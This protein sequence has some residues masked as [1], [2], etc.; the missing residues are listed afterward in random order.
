MSW[1]EDDEVVAT[2]PQVQTLS[3][4][5]SAQSDA[6]WGQDDEVV[7]TANPDL[8]NEHHAKRLMDVR[9]QQAVE[10]VSSMPAIIREPFMAAAGVGANLMSTVTRPFS[11][12]M[13][14]YFAETAQQIA[15]RQEA[16][17]RDDWSPWASRIY[18]GA[19]E[20][21]TQSTIAAPAGPYGIIGSF[22][23]TEGN[24]ALYDAE[25]AGLTGNDRLKYATVQG[26]IEGTVA[27]VFQR[28]APG[29]ERLVPQI[30]SQTMKTSGKQLLRSTAEEIP[31]ELLTELGHAIAES[32]YGIDPNAM[33]EEQIRKRMVDTLGQT[34]LTVG[35]AHATAKVTQNQDLLDALE[36]TRQKGFVTQEEAEQLGMT[37]EES[38][39]RSTRKKAVEDRIDQL[40][41][42]TEELIQNTEKEIQ[43]AGPIPGAETEV[44]EGEGGQDVRRGRKDEVRPE[45]AGEVAPTPEVPV[46][47][48][49]RKGLKE[50]EAA[51]AKEPWQMTREEIATRSMG[52]VP[53]DRV[54]GQVPKKLIAR[55]KTTP[56]QVEEVQQLY[57]EG[58]VGRPLLGVDYGGGEVRLVTGSN[59]AAAA[60]AAGLESIPVVLVDANA[61]SDHLETTGH[62]LNGFWSSDEQA[63]S[64][65]LRGFDDV[66]ANIAEAEGDAGF[67]REQVK[68][69]IREGMTVP[70]EVLADYP[71]L[72][73][74]KSKGLLP[75]P[76]QE[77]P[78]PPTE[79][80]PKPKSR[81]LKPPP[82]APTA[83][84]TLPAEPTPSVPS[85][86]PEAPQAAEAAAEPA[87]E[88]EVRADEG[89]FREA[90]K[91]AKSLNG[92]EQSLTMRLKGRKKGTQKATV[93]GKWAIVGA[94]GQFLVTHVP[95]GISLT[96]TTSNADAKLLIQMIQDSGVALPD[97]NTA[98]ATD[99]LRQ[100]GQVVK[101]WN[102]RDTEVGKKPAGKK[103]PAK[104]PET[105]MH[106]VKAL[107][108]LSADKLT[109]G[110]R[111]NIHEDLAQ[112]G[113]LGAMQGRSGQKGI[114]DLE[115]MARELESGG[116]WRAP[117]GASKG[118]ALLQA[119]KQ[120]AKTFAGME[121]EVAQEYADHQAQLEQERRNAQEQGEEAEHDLREGVRV[122]AQDGL[123]EAEATESET[124]E[125]L[126][127][128]DLSFN[129]GANVAGPKGVVGEQ[130]G[131]FQKEAQGSLFNVSRRP[132]SK[133]ESG[134]PQR[135]DLE[136]IEEELKVGQKESLP[137]QKSLLE[138]DTGEGEGVASMAGESASQR[139]QREAEEARPDV[140]ARGFGFGGGRVKGERVRTDE[141]PEAMR[142]PPEQEQRLEAARGY[143]TASLRDRIS[144]TIGHV[145][146]VLR[147][148]EHIPE[149]AE[150]A[151]D[152]EFFRLMKVVPNKAQDEA[153]RTTAAIVDPLGTNQLRL[154]ERL[155]VMENLSASVALGQPLRFGF[156][157]Q[158]DVDAYRDR[159]RDIASGVP[160]V[161][162]AIDSRKKIVRE[163]VDQLVEYDLLP[164]EALDNVET[165]Y[166]QQV[167]FYMMAHG[168]R[169]GG[170]PGKK[171]RSFQKHRILAE[172]LADDEMDYN[173]SYIEAE[174]SWLTDALIE[175]EKERL[176]R[177]LMER[178]D[179]RPK[180]KEQA[181]RTNFEN[182]VGGKEV[183]SRIDTILGE[184]AES[185]A[186]EDSQDSAERARRKTLIEELERIDPTH[187]YRQQVAKMSAWFKK[188]H[189]LEGGEE[190]DEDGDSGF[191]RLVKE[192]ANTGD[193]PA[194]SLFKAIRER[195]DFIRETLG[196]RYQ[197]WET[198]ADK[199]E[200]VDVFQPEPGNVF[201]R[202]YTLPER[203]VEQLHANIIETAELTKEDLRAVLVLGGPRAQYVV[204][205]E[206]ANQ[207]NASKKVDAP[208]GLAA[209]SDAAMKGWK[210]WTLLNPK[211]AVSYN[212]RNLTGDVDPVV[213]ADPSLLKN[214]G[215]AMQELR[216]YHGD[217]LQISEA[218]R[219]ARD[220]GV[221]DSGF[222]AEEVPEISELPVFRRFMGEVGKTGH[223]L[224]PVRAYFDTVKKYTQFREN[225][226]RYSA[227][228]GYR[229][230]LRQGR[231]KH[232]GGSKKSVVDAIKREMGVDAAAAHLARNLLGDYGN[233]SVAGNWIRRRLAPFWSF[234]EINLKRVPRLVVNAWESGGTMRTAGALSASAGRAI[235]MSRIAWMYAALWIWNH[236]IQGGDEEEELTGFDRATPHV[237]LGRNP[238]GSIRVFR[239]VGALGDF[240]EWFGIN[241]ALAMWPKY[242][243]GQV[244]LGDVLWEMAFATPEKAI[245]SMRPDL[246]ALYE[247]P[248]GTSLFPEPFQPRSVR[249]GEAVSG[250]FGLQDEYQWAKGWALKDGST[251]R[252]HYWQRMIM[253]VVD[254]RQSALSEMYDLRSD[255][256][257]Q[258]G[259]EEA[260]TF[261]VSRY[262]EARDAAMSED[263][264]A[265]VDWKEGFVEENGD[266]AKEKF[267]D[268]LRT[269][270]PIASRLND[271]DEQEFEEKFLTSE[272]RERM[273][274][275]RNYA[276][277]LRDT[278]IS[279]WDADEQSDGMKRAV[280]YSA[281]ERMEPTPQRS[282]YDSAEEYQAALKAHE[283]K[284]EELGSEIRSMV[285]TREEALTLL[286]DYYRRPGRE[287]G[288]EFQKGTNKLEPDYIR[289]RN[290]LRE[291]YGQKS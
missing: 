208:H 155:A 25:Q 44:R 197:T 272:Q 265:F 177:D 199:M 92:V 216:D 102:S 87:K 121:A 233:I 189:G 26:V 113:L 16:T 196:S 130:Q 281:F 17:R 114:H 289:R 249:R 96:S 275:A 124:R 22:A 106:A 193:V 240:L 94:K 273:T 80:V 74:E 73:P 205:T 229:E 12:Q 107:G 24:K 268:W 279:W 201:Y 9:R 159:L 211:R 30:A 11:K 226:M 174:S 57:A 8:L 78:Q 123:S 151:A 251:A 175:I 262:K 246:K 45:P 138:E 132:K 264:G 182:V 178:R 183:A 112:F 283:R 236:L 195:E 144:E 210:V 219:A 85:E 32:E 204:P 125:V 160:E 184:L 133:S 158:E 1:G 200:D 66:A 105:L 27:A 35:L 140:E 243:A 126:G 117:E 202:A 14:D 255:F 203:I 267:K 179:I 51:P 37:P 163:T 225:V 171:K 69:A 109:S 242:Q 81:G 131:L 161:Q 282:K 153:I 23:L 127:E 52:D 250:I 186:S 187:P 70:S 2:A 270:D 39:N 108:G 48:E 20:S 38:K 222:A 128:V 43:D 68:S 55:N 167:H 152:N 13:A 3:V 139:A 122:G 36:Q 61:L 247:V 142:A 191:W 239:R 79:A 170:R 209:L 15:I 248:T 58:W 218:L 164:K 7:V 230:Q 234:Q 75:T 97:K 72:V 280:T 104:E 29:L 40:Q 162:K 168:L 150:F 119:L 64:E 261:P 116:Y 221:V 67:H 10:A 185:R 254:P 50:P 188:E 76:P 49:K 148:Q 274:V 288:N 136:K 176:F 21:L 99:E 34:V 129:F 173:T 213:A 101:T 228:L 224:N 56:Q 220:F 90:R 54:T 91:R 227:F 207:L 95:S 5:H 149:T 245:N 143:Q 31:E 33:N 103:K 53:V 212:L 141:I 147:A 134:V 42:E 198:L 137:G 278:L 28:F 238:D 284:D 214:S 88:T 258:K 120:G 83:P 287:Q 165:Y 146:G 241:E 156:Q 190:T 252:P 237:T 59:R 215:L 253:G 62:D 166:H 71:D 257:K 172:E 18:G 89:Y 235:L 269:I 86:T 154:F 286:R 291:I 277:E 135:S 194:L 110:E 111:I 259:K 47:P 100:I 77:A 206:L 223:P 169:T 63:Q 82:A 231:V 41:K 98:K 217:K 271:K 244:S 232:Y 285:S 192:E 65:M 60:D 290:K 276:G 93:F 19:A 256:L 260:G 180:L 46:E 266:K 118:D 263:Y 4:Q 115:E 84:E 6:T 157:S 145:K 181:K